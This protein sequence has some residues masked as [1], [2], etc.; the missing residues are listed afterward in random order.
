MH[1]V[2][3]VAYAPDQNPTTEAHTCYCTRQLECTINLKCSDLA[4]I[5]KPVIRQ[6][7]AAILECVYSIR[8]VLNPQTTTFVIC[9]PYSNTV[10]LN[11]YAARQLIIVRQHNFNELL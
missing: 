10:S 11:K 4:V 5:L 2:V 6:N 3:V 8:V 7:L 1:V 9:V